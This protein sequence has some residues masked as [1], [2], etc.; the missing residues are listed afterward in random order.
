MIGKL[1]NLF[2]CCSKFGTIFGIDAAADAS[3]ARIILNNDSLSR[4][5]SGGFSIKGM[6]SND[7][8]KIGF[9]DVIDR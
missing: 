9:L 2:R 6:S 8:Q 1:V 5:I 3:L 4:R 7:R